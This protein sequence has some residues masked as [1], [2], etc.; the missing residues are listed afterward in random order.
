MKRGILVILLM[1][2]ACVWAQAGEKMDADSVIHRYAT[3]LDSVV[4]VRVEKRFKPDSWV[5]QLVKNRFNVYDT[6]LRAPKFV[7]FCL[8]V[9]R[10]GDKTFNSYDTAYV[11]SYPKKWKVMLKANTKWNLYHV[12]ARDEGDPSMFFNTEP[13]TQ[14]GF[15]ISFMAVGFEYM[16]DIDNLV[17]GK[18]IDHRLTRFTFTCSRVIAEL[19]YNKSTGMS[20]INKFGDYNQGHFINE[21]FDGLMSSTLG[22]DAFY[23]FNHK[24]YAHAAAYCFS[25]NQLRS[26]GSFILGVQYADQDMSLDLA[27][28]PEDIKPY[29]PWGDQMFRIHHYDYAVNVGYGYNWVF[30]RNWLFNIMATPSIGLRHTVINDVD[31]ARNTM[32]CNLRGRMALVRNCGNFF[33]GMNATFNGFFSWSNKFTI[34]NQ[35]NDV[36]IAAGLRF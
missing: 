30:H 31:N 1:V 20:R 19:Y 3:V 23:V 8:N 10:W 22:L 32:A 29:N 36:T 28:L 14:A 9:Y 13:R 24:K 12:N 6:T 34:Y 33:Y 25:K 21:K 18:A 17:S 26:A 35:N 7:N 27:R 2:V 11:Y 16:P 4:T 5:T 15:R